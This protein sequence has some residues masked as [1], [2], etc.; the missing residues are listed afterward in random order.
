MN[1]FKIIYK[2]LKEL[3]RSMDFEE[4]DAERISPERLG[5]TKE[6]W[7]YL[8]IMLVKAGYIEDVAYYQTLAETRPHI[9]VPITPQLTL[10]GL[11]YLAS[12]SFMKKTAKAAKGIKE[13]IPGL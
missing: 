3:E 11:E 13:T 8:L 9:C 10:N 4:F 7:E 12:I 6:R 5:I 2:I 1:N